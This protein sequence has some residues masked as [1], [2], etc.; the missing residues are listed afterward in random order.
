M[1]QPVTFI[2]FGGTGDLMKRK[3]VPAFLSLFR[4][5]VL[6]QDSVVIGVG[7]RPFNDA[8]YKEFLC[9]DSAE[10]LDIQRLPFHYFMHDFEKNGGMQ[11]LRLFIQSLGRKSDNMIHYLATHFSFFPGIVQQLK[12]SGLQ[13][14]QG[15]NRIAFEKPFGI[16]LASSTMLD[17][18]IHTVFSE[19]QIFRIDHYLA[20]ETVQNIAALKLTNP[21]FEQLLSN[22]LVERIELVI[23]EELGVGN[24]LDSYN[25]VGAVKDMIQSHLLQVISLLLMD[26]P[27]LATADSLH[28]E[29]F[30]VL[31]CLRPLEA[32]RH[33]FGQYKGYL[34]EAQK[35]GIHDSKTETF[36][37]IVLQCDNERWR[38]VD[39]VLRTGKRLAKKYG[40]IRVHFKA[41][42][43]AIAS[44][45]TGIVPNQLVI[46]IYPRQDVHFSINSRKP[47]SW[48][49]VEQAELEFCHEE[50][51][52]P[53]TSDEYA[54]LLADIIEGDKML[55][56]RF[57]ELSESWRIVEQ[58]LPQR[59]EIRFVTYDDGSD[60]EA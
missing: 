24:R 8:E 33:L 57:D 1:Q 19:E 48:H 35:Y 23:D 29:K 39:I 40:Q 6:H 21:F 4:R 13:N 31:Q 2:V 28:D 49:S 55:F 45:Y 52:G 42:S 16:N 5:G 46:D 7:R 44:A 30:S 56:T 43:P 58:I 26:A 41:V 27:Q 15:F 18:E 3:L 54:L 38:G 14:T 36:A 34:D 11:P 37:K 32:D 20:K 53:N 17:R 22:E 50:R 25:D 51:F 47:Q 12:Q 10:A 60:P 59:D 9:E